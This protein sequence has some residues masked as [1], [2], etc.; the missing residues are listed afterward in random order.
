MQFL[1]DPALAP[2]RT[3]LGGAKLRALATTADSLLQGQMG[4]HSLL[5]QIAKGNAARVRPMFGEVAF[6]QVP[7]DT[8]YFFYPEFNSDHTTIPANVKRGLQGEIASVDTNWATVESHCQRYTLAGVADI[9]EIENARRAGF[10]N[11]VEMLITLAS[12]GVRLAGENDRATMVLATGNYISGHD[13]TLANGWD[14]PVNGDSF[15]SIATACKLITTKN[16]ASKRD[17]RVVLTNQSYNAASEDPTRLSRGANV[18]G[19]NTGSPSLDELAAYW[20]VG[21]VVEADAAYTTTN[22][23]TANMTSLYGDVAL[24]QLMPEFLGLGGI[25]Q[26]TVNDGFVDVF[27]TNGANALEPWFD[28]RTTSWWYPYEDNRKPLLIAN[29]THALIR[30][31][32]D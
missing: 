17:C 12:A 2:V 16:Q 11:Y 25:E 8:T 6:R 7:T 15:A 20:G 30:N 29:K 13:I 23:S 5:T 27:V 26:A 9:Q 3:A 1:S 24:V 28:N 32:V 18:L 22:A 21:E 14:D 4:V 31:T 10:I 19:T